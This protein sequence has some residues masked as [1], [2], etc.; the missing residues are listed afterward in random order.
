MRGFR[1]LLLLLSAGLV[2][3]AVARALARRLSV[4]SEGLAHFQER[5]RRALGNAQLR[6]NL[7]HY[8]RTW[9]RQRNTA[10]EAY[11]ERTGRDFESMRRE[12]AARKDEMLA[13]IPRYLTE[14]RSAAERAGAVVYEASSPEDAHRYIAELA[15]R[16]GVELAVKAKSMVSEEIHLNSVLGEQGLRAVETDLGEYVVQLAGQKPSHMISPIAHLN[17]YQ[18]AELLSRESGEQ[19]SGEDI[20]EMTVVARRQLRPEFL[21]GQMGISGANAL[22]AET[23]TVMLVE[24]EGNA[25]LATSLPK[26]HVVVSG[27]EKLIPTMADAMLQLR[28]LSRSGTGQQ[29]TSYTTFVTGRDR[30]DREVHI[31]LLDNGRSD[32]QADPDFEKA[33]RCIRCG[34]CANVCPPYQVVGGHVFGYIYAGA[35]GLVLTP[36]HHGIENGAGPQGLCVSCNACATVCPVEIPLPTQIL[37]VRAKA[38]EWAGMPWYKEAALQVWERPKLF[39]AATRLGAYVQAPFSKNGLMSRVP[40]PDPLAW[41]TPPA[42]A[43]KPARTRLKGRTPRPANDGPLSR[44][45][46]RGLRVAYFVQCVTDKFLPEM[47]EATVR[48]LEAC[49]AT[50]FVPENQHCCGLPAYDA[51]DKAKAL[52]MGKQ[53]V[54]MLEK[55]DADY[56]VTGAAS[57]VAMIVHD[58]PHLFQSS[59]EW[60]ERAGRV[61]SKVVDL[62][63]FLDRVARLSPGALDVGQFHPVTYHNFCQSHNVLGIRDEPRRLITDVLGL[64]LREMDGATTCCGFGGSFSV[65]HPQVSRHIVEQKLANIDATGAPLVITDNPGCII[66]LR[67][68]VDAS[69][70]AVRVLHVAELVDE[71]LRQAGWIP[72][73]RA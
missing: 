5:Y 21:Q 18:V 64:E 37:D 4:G 45:D 62:T 67:G 73:Q 40:L 41:R 71:R 43:T 15:R 60:L 52:V 55:V 47:A 59:P 63:T 53:T 65:D 68:T 57:C 3:A 34:A 28:L 33:L 12:L 72:G 19:L 8:Q 49:G 38:V 50:V 25:R 6:A 44:S 1:R 54:R 69:G 39:D 11:Q 7:V 32:I 42:L 61:A 30:P 14:F 23:G 36:F 51:G 48:V 22:I 24:N 10:F 29:I 2:A 66:H 20:S 16:H 9:R 27:Y 58:Y 17:R 46:A 56:V 26:V 35:I 13:D 70:R 31:V